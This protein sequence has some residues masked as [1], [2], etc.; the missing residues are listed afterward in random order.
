MSTDNAIDWTPP[1]RPEWLA[2]V[3][4]EGRGMDI[5]SVVPLRPREL[6]ET[7][8]ANT[9]LTD[10]GDDDWREPFEILVESIEKEAELHLFGRL[11]TRSDLLIW[12][13]ER[14][15]IEEAYRLHPEIDDE[16][17]D[18]PVFI[19]G[20]ARSGTSILFELLSA[21]R[22]FGAPANWEIMFP[23]P[24][25]EAASYRNDPRIPKAHHLLTQWHRVAPSFLSMHELGATIPNECKVAMNCTFVSDNLT[26]LFQ[27]PSYYGW[28]AQADL[29]GSYAYYRRM[30]K[31]LQWKNPRRHWLL[32]SPSHIESLPVLFKVF[33]DAHVVYT[34]RDPVKARA[35]VT[36]LLGTLYWMRSDKAFDAASFE[37]LMTPE[38]Y[39]FSLERVI[40]QI[41]SGAIPRGRMHDF[42]FA[43]LMRDPL[44]AL[45]ELYGKLELAFPEEARQAVAAYLAHKPQGKFGQNVYSVG[46]PEQIAR[47]RALF[48]RYQRFHGVPDEV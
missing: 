29:T 38:A 2:R 3:N 40:E 13:E 27:V 43:D 17:V 45:A 31:L 5:A 33:P 47:E 23:C 1:P 34:H 12:L 22:R 30:L 6:I 32:K 26:G 46:D 4:E 14:L 16:A 28:L 7:A 21:D 15:R 10:F 19:V 24:P 44:A 35:S 48:A 9:G 25:P 37:R 36:N 8:I 18:A 20:Q 39:A 11:M 42:R 41:E